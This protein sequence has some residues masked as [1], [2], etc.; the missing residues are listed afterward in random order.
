MSVDV[1][2]SPDTKSRRLFLAALA[3]SA[4]VECQ[5]EGR[6]RPGACSLGPASFNVARL[7]EHVVGHEPGTCDLCDLYYAARTQVVRLRTTTGQ[8]AGIVV[9]DSGRIITNMHLVEGDD[10]PTVETYAG[11]MSR[12]KTLRTR[13]ELDLALVAV[14]TPSTGWVPMRVEHRGLPAV[15]SDVYVIGHPVGLGWTVT[16]GIVSAVR[17]AGEIAPI[18]LIQTDAAIS[19]GNSGGPLLDRDG[20][21][22]GIVAAKLTG[23][24]IENVAFAIPASVAAEF[25]A[26]TVN[27]GP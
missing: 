22:V 7:G 8:G 18:D 16:R 27:G 12:A 24:G 25:I 1:M 4:C 15:G 13:A 26:Q 23:R 17:K 5:H 19:A 21:L 10:T 2:N 9:S 14:D 6:A 11:K 20:R 3:L